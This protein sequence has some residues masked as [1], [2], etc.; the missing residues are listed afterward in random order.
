MLKESRT[1]EKPPKKKVKEKVERPR[2]GLKRGDAVSVAPEIFDGKTPGSF[3]KDNPD[4]QMGT[5]VRVWSGRKLAQIEW[6][7]GSKDLCRFDQ[8]RVERLKVNAAFM[9]TVMMMNALK[10]PRDA[11][12]KE[13]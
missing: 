8:L 6:T 4:R 9:V 10:K 13:G 12:D 5:V 1:T 2:F 11:M 7:D 3:S